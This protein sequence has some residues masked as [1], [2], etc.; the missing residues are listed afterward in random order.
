MPGTHP[1]QYLVSRGRNVLYPQSLS[2][3]LSNCLQNGATSVCGTSK[4]PRQSKREWQSIFY[5]LWR[6]PLGTFRLCLHV[7]INA[8]W[9]SVTYFPL[10]QLVP[11]VFNNRWRRWLSFIQILPAAR[12]ALWLLT[13]LQN[14]FS[15]SEFLFK[16]LGSVTARHL[17]SR[18]Q[19][20]F[21]ALNRGR[22]LYSAGRPSHWALAHISGW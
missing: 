3:L 11:P 14:G 13:T 2:K 22:H 17:I 19:P 4:T 21:V 9:V 15:V 7:R 1:R 5:E 6:H 18:R 10:G 16:C 20:N 12:N 8:R